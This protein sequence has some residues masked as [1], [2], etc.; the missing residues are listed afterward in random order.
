MHRTADFRYDVASA[1]SQGR[2]EYQE[3]A[4]VSDFAAGA[5]IG[6]AVVADGMGGHAAGDVASKIVA[7]EVFTELKLHTGNPGAMENSIQ[8]ILCAAMYSANECVRYHSEQCPGTEGMGATLIAPV[9]VQD[10]LYWGSVGDSPLYLFRRGTLVRLNADHSLVP[11]IDYLVSKGLMKPE[12]ALAHPDRHCLTSV[13]AGKA[14]PQVDCP[15]EAVKLFDGDIVVAASDGLQFLDDIEITNLLSSMGDLP[16]DQISDRLMAE[17]DKLDDPDQD[18][19][20]VCVMR[21]HREAVAAHPQA[22]RPRVRARTKILTLHPT[23][24]SVTVMAA[25]SGNK[26]ALAARVS[27]E[28]LAV[29]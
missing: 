10:R 5:G 12:E 2:R 21:V 22:D 8:D 1:I 6:F 7:T 3:D 14:I 24:P 9:L 27:N 18:N 4:V 13:L 23:N 25:V 11:Q 15:D 19:V 28:N 29:K 16:A 26:T 17:I 20:S